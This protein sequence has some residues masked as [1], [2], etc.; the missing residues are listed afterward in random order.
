MTDATFREIEPTRD[1]VAVSAF[2]R[3]HEWPFHGRRRLTPEQAQEMEFGPPTTRTFWIELDGV[4]VGLL[5]LQDLDDIGRGSPLFDLR[6]A[7]DFRGRGVGRR[8]VAWLAELVFREYP[9]AHRIEAAT[10]FDNVAMRRVL[11]RCGFQLEG[12]LREAWPTEDGQR[13]DT[14]I[15]GLLRSD[16]ERAK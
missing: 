16:V 12:R 15:Y 14:A 5:R 11:E 1:A 2:L 6:I 3:A 13:M 8:A 4:P 7:P 10:R 9:A